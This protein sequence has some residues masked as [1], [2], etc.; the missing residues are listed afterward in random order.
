MNHSIFQKRTRIVF[1]LAAVLVV[2]WVIWLIYYASTFHVVST[3]P[4]M[5]NVATD[6]SSIKISFNRPISSSNLI[7]VSNPSIVTST[8]VSYK[9]LVLSLSYPLNQSTRYTLTVVSVT[10]NLGKQLKNLVFTFTPKYVPYANLPVSQQKTIFQ[11]PPTASDQPP[12]FGDTSGLINQGLSTQQVQDYE[13][14]VTAFAQTTNIKLSSAIINQSS[15]TTGPINPDGIFVINFSVSINE[16]VYNA[17]FQYS[18]LNSGEL[19]LHNTSSGSQVF[20][21]G[22]LSVGS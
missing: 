18:G 8:K 17:S 2:F 20:D 6:S 5:S 1:V 13:Q 21:S 19:F 7:V 10:D 15:I 11:Q 12:D 9:A 4:G 16:T 3:N 14:G 22:I